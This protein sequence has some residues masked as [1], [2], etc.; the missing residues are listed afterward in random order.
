MSQMPTIVSC[1]MND[2]ANYSDAELFEAYLSPL[3][4]ECIS[5][6]GY[7]MRY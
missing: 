5:I 1:F 4:S 3:F 7:N 2:D 6:Y